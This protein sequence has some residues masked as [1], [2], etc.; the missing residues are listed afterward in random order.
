[1]LGPAGERPRRQLPLPQR[2]LPVGLAQRLL[3]GSSRTIGRL[4]MRQPQQHGHGHEH[5]GGHDDG[6]ETQLDRIEKSV[7][8]QQGAWEQF[9]AE[10][11]PIKG[12]I[13]KMPVSQEV[14][15]ALDAVKAS[16]RGQ[17]AKEHEQFLAAQQKQADIA[18]GKL[19]ELNARIDELIAKGGTA[20][21]DE[22]QGIKDLAT[23]A[24]EAVDSI[25]PNDDNTPT[26]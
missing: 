22:V 8:L 16:I 1:M 13:E 25:V 19:D 17:A 18:N 3:V 2:F 12:R 5:G 10:W 23:D 15:D 9:L 24:A 11:A 26:T 7:G 4:A 14:Q 20:S 6:E 21:A